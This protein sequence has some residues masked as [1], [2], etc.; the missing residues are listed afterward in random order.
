MADEGDAGD[1]EPDDLDTAAQPPPPAP[2]EF[3]FFVKPWSQV[4]LDGMYLGG[5]QRPGKPIAVEGGAHTLRLV[6]DHEQCPPGHPEK[7]FALWVDGTAMRVDG[8]AV[9]SGKSWL[10]WDFATGARCD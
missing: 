3:S 2:G 5:L 4:Y 7:S 6:C 10:C 8:L 9:T 1:A